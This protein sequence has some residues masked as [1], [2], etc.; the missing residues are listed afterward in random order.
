MQYNKQIQGL[1]APCE[2]TLQGVSAAVWSGQ[3]ETGNLVHTMRA[4]SGFPNTL[5]SEEAMLSM[6]KTPGGQQRTLALVAAMKPLQTAGRVPT[7]HS[8]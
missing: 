1:E 2:R 4:W 5:A 3:G 8:A 7:F 6:Y